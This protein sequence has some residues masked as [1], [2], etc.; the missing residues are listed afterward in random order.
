SGRDPAASRGDKP[1]A[2]DGLV[3]QARAHVQKKDMSSPAR[4]LQQLI[5]GRGDGYLP[6]MLL[7]EVLM[8]GPSLK[9]AR[10]HYQKAR[11]FRPESVEPI[12]RLAGLARKEG[13]IAGEKL[14][15]REGLA[16]DGMSYDPA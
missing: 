11:G 7:A 15:L 14:L 1:D 8:Q 5:V 4:V 12:V 6:R 16:I 13:D 2:R 3:A 9:Q 10:A